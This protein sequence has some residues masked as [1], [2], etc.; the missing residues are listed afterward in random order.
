LAGSLVMEQTV[1]THEN[2]DV[3]QLEKGMYQVQI[4]TS[5]GTFAKKLMVD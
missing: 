1:S 5:K 3:T 2:I 4:S